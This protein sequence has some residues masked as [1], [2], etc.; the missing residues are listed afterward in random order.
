MSDSIID[1]FPAFILADCI[2][3]IKKLIASDPSKIDIIP[4][5]KSCRNESF[6][7]G[8]S[9]DMLKFVFKVENIEWNLYHAEFLSQASQDALLRAINFNKASF[10]HKAIYR[11]IFFSN[12]SDLG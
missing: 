3:S 6:L 12:Q 7:N 11:E 4:L 2:D 1:I 9:A 5:K 10:F 8:L